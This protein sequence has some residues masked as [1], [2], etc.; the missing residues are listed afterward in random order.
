[1][2]RALAERTEAL[3]TAYTCAE[4]VA[5]DQSL[6]ANLQRLGEQAVCG[7]HRANTSSSGSAGQPHRRA[8]LGQRPDHSRPGALRPGALGPSLQTSAIT[9]PSR[10]DL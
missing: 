7:T 2:G 9:L 4:I 5:H 3:R 6:P 1:M 8:R 10:A